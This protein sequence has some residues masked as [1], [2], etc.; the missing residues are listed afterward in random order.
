MVPPPRPGLRRLLNASIIAL[1]PAVNAGFR[2]D[3]LA[4][5]ALR[6]FR[7]MLPCRM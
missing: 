4:R 2:I 7:R 6:P 1:S 3:E 5:C